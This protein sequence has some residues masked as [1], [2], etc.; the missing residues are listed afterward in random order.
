[1]NRS[2]R[3][4]VRSNGSISSLSVNRKEKCKDFCRK[5]IAFMCT[6]VGVGGLI[7]AYA[8]VGAASFISIETDEKSAN[9]TYV[10]EVNVMRNKYANELWALAEKNNGINE[11]V[12]QSQMNIKLLDYQNYLVTV[13]KKGYDGRT[14]KEIWSFPAALMF[15]L[16]VFSMIGYGNMTQFMTFNSFSNKKHSI[17]CRQHDATN[18]MGEGDHGYLRSFRHPVVR[19]VLFEHGQSV[20]QII[21]MALS[22]VA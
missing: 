11:T 22:Q 2:N 21:S 10:E 13:I 16:S 19:L 6:Q 20:G 15:C 4:S 14:L 18:R 9:T 7:V 5:T 17:I 3:W 8:L 1:M 12:W